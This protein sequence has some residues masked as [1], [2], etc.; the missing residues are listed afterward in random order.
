MSIRKNTKILFKDSII[1]GVGNIANKLVSVILLPLLTRYLTIM[2]VGVLALL[3]M[4]E[5]ILFNLFSS[6]IGN[7]LYRY[8]DDKDKLYNK[9]L[10]SSGFWF[11]TIITAGLSVPVILYSDGLTD[12]IGIGSEYSKLIQLTVINVFF[13]VV[14][15]YLLPIWRYDHKRFLFTSVSFIKFLSTVGIA[16]FLI[17]FENLGIWGLLYAKILANLIVSIF[18]IFI[19]IKDYLV[20]VSLKAFLKI[21]NY[22]LHF[23]LLSLITPFLNT[24]N[25]Y[26]INQY[27]DLSDVAIFSIAM[28]IGLIVNMVIVT[29]MQ[30]AWQPLMYK[31]GKANENRSYFTDYSNYYTIIGSLIVVILSVIS[32]ILIKLLTT[33]AYM[34]S[35]KIIPFIAVAYLIEG[36]R[37]FFMSGI[38]LREKI[39][40]L[41]IISLL[42]IIVNLML[43]VIL[44]TNFHIWG[45]IAALLVSYLLLALSVLYKSQKELKIFWDWYR[46]IKIFSIMILFIIINYYFN[47]DGHLYLWTILIPIVFLT[48]LFVLG[49][50]GKKEISGMRELLSKLKVN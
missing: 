32:P 2:E 12:L 9:I 23:I 10:I 3:E 8:F 30:L 27:L 25:R 1:Y 33:D 6:G 39:G 44:I 47:I 34:D 16:C 18:T 19:V 29:P 50:I 31:L 42:I 21:Q 26:F 43:N 5:L 48:L 38:A 36:F 40:V 15:N 7:G 24:S 13:M 4:L 45:A 17:I 22:G 20:S 14:S 49:L 46:K 37:H 35:V 11:R 28:K 41:S